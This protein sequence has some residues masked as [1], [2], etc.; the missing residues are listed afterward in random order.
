[1]TKRDAFVHTHDTPAHPC[2]VCHA[3]LDA[4]TGI[5]LSDPRPTLKVGDITCCAYCRAILVV[6][7]L[8]FRLATDEDLADVEPTLRRVLFEFSQQRAPRR[9]S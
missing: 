1:V 7:T 9:S 5:S 2:P 3:R 4:A 6:T 8:G